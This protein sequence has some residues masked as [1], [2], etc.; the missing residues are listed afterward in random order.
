MHLCKRGRRELDWQDELDVE[1]TV[2]TP[3]H[4]EPS[5]STRTQEVLPAR[6]WGQ[7]LP[8]PRALVLGPRHHGGLTPEE[9]GFAP[10]LGR[11]L[12]APGCRAAGRRVGQ[13][14]GRKLKRDK[15]DRRGRPQP[16]PELCPFPAP[17]GRL[18]PRCS[19][20]QRSLS[21]HTSVRILY[22]FLALMLVAV[23]VLASLVFRKVDSLSEDISLAQAI[24]DKKLVSM[25]ENLQGLDLKAPSNCSFCH[26]AGQLGQDIRSLQQ[27]LAGMQKTLLAQEAQLGQAAQ[28]HELLSTTTSRL[29]RETGSCSFSIHQVN[30]SL[31]FFLTQ[32]RG[33]QATTSG[34]DLSLKDL[35]QECYSVKAALQQVNFTAG[36]TSEWIHGIRRKTDEETLT[37]QKVVTDW[38]NYTRLFGSLR[39]TSAKTGEV[40]KSIQAALGT[41][42]QRISQNSESVHDL[43]LQ[44]MGLQLQ[45]D[46]ISSFLDDHEENMH[47]LQ[48]HTRYAQNRTAERFETLEGRMASHEIEIGTIFANINATDSH[49]HSM[50]KY[51]DDVRLSCT[52][53]FHA[54]A[55]ELYYLNKSVALMLGT[56]AL[57]QERFGLLSARLDFNVRNLSMVMEE[58]KAV[59]MRHGQI[60]RN[61]TVVRGAP[62]PP[63]PRGLKGDAGVKGPPGSRG[64][65][66][67]SGDLG[68]PGPQGPQGQ[69][70]DPGPMGE[71][72]PAGLRGIPGFKGS[73][74]SIGTGGPRGQP[75][76]KGDVGPPGP[77]GPPG[78]PGPSGPQGKPGIAGKTGSPGQRG[79]TGPKGEPG[80]QGPPGLPGPPGPPG[81]QSRY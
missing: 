6:P 45:L 59:D 75:G 48:Y 70:G 78:S 27:E 76:A 67:D 58:M 5:K 34:L 49:V 24:Y 39:A 52:L 7:L 18:G 40:V 19:R 15:V 71:R 11:P 12:E 10:G 43:V 57:L 74:G 31:G 32:V 54:H 38:Q 21:L 56:A 62:G 33:W 53:G 17:T 81:S 23:A 72:G 69:P 35:A 14:T 3:L 77:E 30:Q 4:F 64:P 66:G 42:S 51:L 28:T 65:K 46:N 60:L 1:S 36:Q 73:K 61:V 2:K 44:V 80:I 22:L 41:S 79:P 9:G 63:G 16:R 13:R 26:E 20:C 37:L 50:L 47:D 55:E 29:A 25:Q 68:P 8:Y